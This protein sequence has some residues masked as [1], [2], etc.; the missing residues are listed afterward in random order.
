MRGVRA[1]LFASRVWWGQSNSPRRVALCKLREMEQRSLLFQFAFIRACRAVV[2]R[3]RV[4]RGPTA[5]F[6]PR[7]AKF[8]G[9]IGKG[10]DP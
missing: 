6:L 9:G 8:F 2:L 10:D 5:I 7:G 1:P 3:R 4:F